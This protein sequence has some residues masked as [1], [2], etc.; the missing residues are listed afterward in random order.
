MKKYVF[1][2]LLFLGCFFVSLTIDTSKMLAVSETIVVNPYDSRKINVTLEELSPRTESIKIHEI[3][4]CQ[5]AS[6]TDCKEV[7]ELNKIIKI[8]NTTLFEPIDMNRSTTAVVDYTIVSKTDGTKT[9]FVEPFNGDG[10]SM[11][12]YYHTFE[13]ELSTLN[14]RVVINADANGDPLHVYDNVQ[15]ISV[16]VLPITIELLED[17]VAK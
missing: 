15:Y 1:S 7:K 3:E 17:E 6:E 12:A 11:K 10:E 4:Y 5:N 14:Q 9:F 16:R 2:I 8:L 13:Y